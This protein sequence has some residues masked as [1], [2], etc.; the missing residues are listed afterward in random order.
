MGEVIDIGADNLNEKNS[1]SIIQQAIEIQ[2]SHLLGPK[3]NESAGFVITVWTFDEWTELLRS[4]SR[5]IASI[6]ELGR[7]ES[8]CVVAKLCE[9]TKILKTGEHSLTIDL[10]RAHENDWRYLYQAAV[11]GNCRGSRKGL[12]IV[13]EAISMTK[14][15]HFVTDFMTSPSNNIASSRML[16]RLGF[17]TLGQLK[18]KDYRG[19]EPTTWQVMALT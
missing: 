13:R 17:K 8:Y 2:K 3:S 1:V 6:D 12:E 11:S 4:G 16:E 14:A 18:I 15:K 10:F 7:L 5:L 9:F 19:F